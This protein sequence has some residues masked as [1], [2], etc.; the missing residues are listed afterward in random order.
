[1]IELDPFAV[2]EGVKA[3]METIETLRTSSYVPDTIMPPTA[4]IPIPSIDYRNGLGRSRMSMEGSILVFTSK[5]WTR[6]GQKQLTQFAGL[7]SDLS[8]VRAIDGDR[9]LGGLGVTCTI[10]E[11]R[12]LTAEEFGEVGYCGGVFTYT[13]I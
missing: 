6:E 7:N 3:R 5:G 1:M 8:V 4:V 11:F 13:I 12:E 2:M 10:S 9:T